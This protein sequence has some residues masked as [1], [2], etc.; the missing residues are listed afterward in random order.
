M[1]QL[2]V[3]VF[4]RLIPEGLPLPFLKTTLIELDVPRLAASRAWHEKGGKELGKD[5]EDIKGVGL[6]GVALGKG[7]DSFEAIPEILACSTPGDTQQGQ[8]CSPWKSM[9]TQQIADRAWQGNSTQAAKSTY[10]QPELQPGCNSGW[11]SISC[12]TH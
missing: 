10:F 8:S 9:R 5:P 12:S 3:V 11:G 4:H 7:E 1:G 6:C 2:A